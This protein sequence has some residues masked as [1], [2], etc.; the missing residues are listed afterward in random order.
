MKGEMLVCDFVDGG[1][2]HMER[3]KKE[4]FHQPTRSIVFELSQE[5]KIKFGEI[6]GVE[7][8]FSHEKLTPAESTDRPNEYVGNV[9]ME[10]V[11]T[12]YFQAD[13]KV[14]IN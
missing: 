10:D 5:E 4:T 6:N 11:Y 13:K 7:C 8:T 12:L 1:T 2:C 3:A 9:C 14:K